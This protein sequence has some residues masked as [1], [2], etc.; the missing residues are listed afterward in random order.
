MA[1]C[2]L[3]EIDNS[4]IPRKSNNIHTADRQLETYIDMCLKN[5]KMIKRRGKEFCS[6]YKVSAMVM[7][8]RVKSYMS[9]RN[10]LIVAK[11]DWNY[12]Q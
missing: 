10:G 7:E 1:T 4:E 12:V 2:I 9:M 5:S 6:C 3:T 11:V 8:K